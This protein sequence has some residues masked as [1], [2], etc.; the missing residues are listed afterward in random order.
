MGGTKQALRYE[1]NSLTTG[2]RRLLGPHVIKKTI[3]SV[4]YLPPR[5]SKNQ[6]EARKEKTRKKGGLNRGAKH[7][8]PSLPRL[9][10]HSQSPSSLRSQTRAHAPRARARRARKWEPAA[11]CRRGAGAE[12]SHS[13]SAD[14]TSSG[15]GRSPAAAPTD[16]LSPNRPGEYEYRT[17]TRTARR[18]LLF[19]CELTN[20]WFYFFY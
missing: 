8:H 11:S 12:A 18:V 1:S 6:T 19:A 2:I 16:P 10:S 15:P 3:T 9:L 5:D 20:W 14:S 4:Q 7:T 17:V 13:P